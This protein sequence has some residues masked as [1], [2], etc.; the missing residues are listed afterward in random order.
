MRTTDRTV[1]IVGAG[2]SGTAVAINLLR[3]SHAQPLRVVLLDRMRIGRG[4][5]YAGNQSRYLLNVPAGRMSATSADPHE[6]LAFAQRTLPHANEEDFLPRDL[7][8]RYLESSLLSAARSLPPHVRLGRMNAE[9]IAIERLPRASSLELFMNDGERIVADSVVL[10]LGNP[11]PTPLPGCEALR[12]GQYVANPWQ[13]P[14]VMRR[15]ETVLVVG[16]GLT[17][18]DVTLAGADAAKGRATFHAISRHGLVPA[19]QSALTHVEDERNNIALLRAAS[20]SVRQLVRAARAL[21]ENVALRGADWHEAI[22]IIR[23]IAPTLW[24]RLSAAERRRF[25]RHVRPYWEVHRH[26]LPQSSWAALH[27]LRRRGTLH[28]HAGRILALASDGARVRVTWRPRGSGSSAILRVDRVINCTGPDNDVRRSRERLLRMLLA[29]GIAVADPLG[30]G[31]VTGAFGAVVDASG[32][33]ARN[34]HYIGP[35][36]RPSHWETTA[37]QELRV[38]AEQLASHLASSVDTWPQVRASSH[39]QCQAIVRVI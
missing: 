30:L 35:L 14:D 12:E 10:A 13:A 7:F 2:F 20:V 8:G 24:Q 17:M 9:V 4:T 18:A 26:R 16:T 23:S 25:L 31:L 37:V 21:S 19:A 3:L 6:F 22:R 33:T 28:V 15:G 29:Q 32:R 27:A 39:A 5:A 34:L 1:V 36:L 11:P 38:H